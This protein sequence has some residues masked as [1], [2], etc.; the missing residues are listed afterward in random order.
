MQRGLIKTDFYL[1]NGVDA[2]REGNRIPETALF[3]AENSRFDG[4]RWGS[5]KGYTTFGSVQAGGTNIKGLIPY[6]RFPSGVQTPHL[7]SYYN[8]IFYRYDLDDASYTAISPA[9][10]TA[11][12]TEVE[13]VSYNGILYVGDGANL[14]GKIS[15][16][17]FTTVADSPRARLLA[18]WAEKIWAVDNVAPATAQYTA[19][20]TASSPGNAEAWTG[21]GSGANLIGK[22][23]RIESMKALNEKLYFFKQDQID[24]ATSFYTDAAAPV[25]NLQP[26]SKNTGAI[27]NRATT[28][29]E[30]DIW[31]LAPNLEVR[32]LGHEANY[33][34]DTRTKDISIAIKRYRKDLDSDQSGAVSWYQD[35]TYKL[36]LKGNGS[37]QNNIYFTF[38]RDSGGWGFDK[39]TSPQV[40]CTVAGKSFFGVG[41]NNGQIYRDENG[42][43]DNGF[44]MSW[45]GK[46]G[47]RDDGRADV[48]KYG[49]YL[50]V[51]GARSENVVATVRLVG[52]DYE[53]LEPLTIPA[54]TAAEIAAGSVEDD[55]GMV[56]DIVGGEGYNGVEVGA[57]PVYRFNYMFSISSTARMFG[58]EVESSLLAQ[59]IYID[60]IRIK[61]IPRGDRYTPVNA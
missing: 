11:T 41:G 45:G 35:G 36:A 60:E 59:R 3:Y 28:V 49:R 54:P 8:E 50:F 30:N 1:F 58:A 13:G 55:W 57:P 42:Y 27:N 51:R 44:P 29:V 46:T 25:L 21:G 18:T 53:V 20:A 32:S 38:D 56:G 24:V 22:G 39:G 7:V 6:E 40:A 9:A 47:L 5:R 43:S 52:E 14:I 2:F 19:T 16:T 48:Y 61:Y 31:F 34:E 17:S 4:G 23:G 15:N 26:V 10:W 33:F 37:S 12:D